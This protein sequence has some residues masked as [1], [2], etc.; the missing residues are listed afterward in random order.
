MLSSR[1]NPEDFGNI[2]DTRLPYE[3]V[4][5]VEMETDIVHST[6]YYQDMEA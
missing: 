2:T 3:K 4:E 6:F 5:C 1:W